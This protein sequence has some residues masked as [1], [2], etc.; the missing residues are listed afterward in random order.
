MA[1]SG[2]DNNDSSNDY[3]VVTPDNEDYSYQENIED[4]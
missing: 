1:W 3:Y 4:Q 2:N